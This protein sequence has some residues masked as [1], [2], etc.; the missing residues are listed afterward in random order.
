LAHDSA[1]KC[2][3]ALLVLHVQWDASLNERTA[4]FFHILTNI[5]QE[6]ERIQQQTFAAARCNA[7]RFEESTTYTSAPFYMFHMKSDI[8]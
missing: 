5:R 2:R 6:E 8:K 4:Y 3:I 1:L 7:D